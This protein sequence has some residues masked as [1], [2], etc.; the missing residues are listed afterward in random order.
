MCSHRIAKHTI[1]RNIVS[2][3]EHVTEN[4]QDE[5]VHF[6]P[7]EYVVWREGTVFTGVCLSSGREGRVPSLWSLLL[8]G[9]GGLTSFLPP[10][11][12][13][14]PWPGRLPLPLP[15]PGEGYPSLPCQ[16][17]G[18]PSLLPLPA[19]GYHLPPPSPPFPPPPPTTHTESGG[20]CVHAGELSCI[21]MGWKAPKVRFAPILKTSQ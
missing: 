9:G 18:N 19:Q 21:Q 7:P 11:P 5:W 3:D 15:W 16:D 6:L 8:F 1:V 4:R 10:L 20:L 2:G 12:Y 14:S 17:R 13:P